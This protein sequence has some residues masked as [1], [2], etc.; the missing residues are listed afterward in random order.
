MQLLSKG[1]FVIFIAKRSFDHNFA[2][3][4]KTGTLYFTSVFAVTQLQNLDY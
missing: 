1:E 3:E 2:E 4:I